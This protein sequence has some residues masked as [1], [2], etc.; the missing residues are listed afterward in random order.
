MVK[1][2]RHN[3]L[4]T[5]C[6][7][8]CQGLLPGDFVAPLLCDDP[9]T[10][11]ESYLGQA[12]YP[13]YPHT[14]VDINDR[15]FCWASNCY[16][17]AKT[18]EAVGLHVVCLGVFMEHCKVVDSIDR[19]WAT[20]GQKNLWNGAPGLQLDRESEVEIDLVRQKA[21][22]YGV[23]LLARLP[24]EL[25]HM[26]YK[27]SED[28][29]FWRCILAL[30][31][32]RELSQS[33]RCMTMPSPSVP[34]C[35]IVAWARG[36]SAVV[37]SDECPPYIRLTLDYRGIRKIERLQ[38]R[39][40]YEPAYSNREVF[41]LTCESEVKDVVAI[42]EFN[43]LRL[44]LPNHIRG[45]QVWD[46]PSPP[47]LEDCEFYGRVSQ[48]MQLKTINLYAVS[49][50]TF[51]FSHSKLYA[52]HAHTHKSPHATTT[53][54]RLSDT[55]RANAVSVY[56]PIPK[57]EEIIAIIIRLRSSLEGGQSTAQKPFFLF[58]TKLAGDIAVG[59]YR[60]GAHKDVI[61]GQSNPKLFVYSS[62]DVGPATVFGTY[63]RKQHGNS[64]SPSF[65]HPWFSNPPINYH[66][67]ISSAPL[68]NVIRVWVR[69][70]E[71][72]HCHGMLLEYSNGAQRALGD[73]RVGNYLP[74]TDCVK[75]YLNPSQICYRGPQ[76]EGAGAGRLS[77]NFVVNASD[78]HDHDHDAD[79]WICSSLKGV[80]EFWFSRERSVIRILE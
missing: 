63:P 22:S 7:I 18:P 44:Q 11:S 68:E 27:Y 26:I 62:S 51:F 52:V 48:S 35:N 42:L 17:C 3:R 49:G 47:R 69:E 80:L 61:L 40:P 16:Q 43:V 54:E 32:A 29:V 31:L 59:P 19:L 39:P 72:Q 30:S 60:S 33:Q 1:S 53:F 36:K 74:G 50:L 24:A 66:A 25:T 9:N 57:G 15:S 55:R 58:R 56:L 6:G 10:G 20:V 34:L 45:F 37:G 78:H 64:I 12:V 67:N 73:Y 71:D 77:L 65:P 41:I 13:G 23:T 8:C 38:E 5:Q 4:R 46:T 14:S 79:G 76:D 28:A 21:E 70:D 75:K 2:L